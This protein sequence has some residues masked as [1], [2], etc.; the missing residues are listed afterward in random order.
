ME[1]ERKFL[2]DHEKWMMVE[3]PNPSHIVQAYI[4]NSLDKTLRIRI[5]GKTGYL[6]IKGKTVGISRSEFE[7][8]IPLS[9]AQQMIQQFTEKQISKYRY[10][11]MVGKHLWEVDE[12]HGKLEGL[13]LAEIELKSED[14]NFELP[15]WVAEDVSTDPEYYNS[16]LIE[17]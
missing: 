8:E 11:L 14:E 10:E 7:Y 6:T 3:K 12:F 4:M 5:K 17:R 15:F 2:V 13:I 16:R 1:I 9:D